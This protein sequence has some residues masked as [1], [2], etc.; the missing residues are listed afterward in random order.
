[1]SRYLCSCALDELRTRRDH[2]YKER[3]PTRTTQPGKFLEEMYFCEDCYEPRCADCV[4]A[5]VSTCY[6]PQCYV[7]VPNSSVD[8]HQAN[9]PRNCLRCPECM[10]ILTIRGT[11]RSLPGTSLTSPETSQPSSPYYYACSACLWDSKHIQIVAEKPSDLP[12]TY[13]MYL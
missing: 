1:M 2:T 4:T 5:E 3:I 9:C 11:D 6:C 8:T 7:E 12:C 10:H 13:K